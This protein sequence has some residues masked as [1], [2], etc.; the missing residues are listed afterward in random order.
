MNEWEGNRGS[1]RGR[2]DWESNRG[3]G[4]SINEWEGNWG[5]GGSSMGRQGRFSGMGPQGYQRSAERITEEI[6]DQLTWHGDLDATNIQVKVEQG[7]VTL[8]GTVDSRYAKR[9]AEDIAESIRGVQDINNQ[10]QVRREHES[11]QRSNQGN[12]A[13]AG[14]T[15]TQTSKNARNTQS[16]NS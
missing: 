5:Y 13:S 4:R 16:V 3:F 2:R 12:G 8:T 10:L 6:N 11:M 9:M 15:S 14:Q 1:S 7:I